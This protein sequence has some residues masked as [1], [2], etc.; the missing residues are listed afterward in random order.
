M[1]HPKQGRR[2]ILYAADRKR[3]LAVDVDEQPARLG[4][5]AGLAV[6]DP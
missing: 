4:G 5:W 6:V 2:E 1:R 3:P